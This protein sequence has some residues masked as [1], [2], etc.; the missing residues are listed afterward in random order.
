M[1]DKTD[2][3]WNILNE[4]NSSYIFPIEPSKAF[5]HLYSFTDNFVSPILVSD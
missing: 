1:D 4:S 5:P 3:Q 2:Y